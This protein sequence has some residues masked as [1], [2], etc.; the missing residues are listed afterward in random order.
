M[1]IA[2]LKIE[3]HSDFD[4]I[5]DCISYNQKEENKEL[6]VPSC[7]GVPKRPWDLCDHTNRSGQSH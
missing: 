2:E 6:V 5:E 3:N 4:L 1:N 7:C